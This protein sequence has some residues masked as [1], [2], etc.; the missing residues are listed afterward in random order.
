MLG[1][2]LASMALALADPPA[3]VARPPALTVEIRADRG[4]AI[5]ACATEAIHVSKA[6]GHS[7]EVDFFGTGGPY[8]QK[9]SVTDKDTLEGIRIKYNKQVEDRK[10]LLI[11]TF[12]VHWEEK[13]S[14]YHEDSTGER[15]M[16]MGGLAKNGKYI[17]WL[18]PDNKGRLW[19]LYSFRKRLFNAFG[20]VGHVATDK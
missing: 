13:D 19:K 6:I 3:I 2:F 12:H 1:I 7:V 5:E 4:I 9:F 11:D 18:M 14:F 15:V 10:H 8:C 16:F 17:R 20:M